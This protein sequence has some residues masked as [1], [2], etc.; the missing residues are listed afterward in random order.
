[1]NDVILPHEYNHGITLRCL[2]HVLIPVTQILQR[3]AEMSF[4]SKNT[5]ELHFLV[6]MRAKTGSSL[7][8]PPALQSLSH[9]FQVR[10]TL[11]YASMARG[12]KHGAKVSPGSNAQGHRQVEVR[13]NG[14]A[15]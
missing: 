8:S 9:H 4:T 7:P 10:F 11:K 1:M 3:R 15:L 6:M 12:G 2:K 13:S 14:L 5:V